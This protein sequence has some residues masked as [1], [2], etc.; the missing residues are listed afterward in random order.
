[1]VRKLFWAI[2]TCA[3]ALVGFAPGIAFAA[4]D[5]SDFL[6]ESNSCAT[7]YDGG[8][9]YT[10]GEIRPS[11]YCVNYEYRVDSLQY[12]NNINPGT[13][14][15]VVRWSF[16]SYYG[17]SESGT[18]ELHFTICKRELPF[19]ELSEDDDAFDEWGEVAWYTGKEIRPAL[20]AWES[21]AREGVDYT[22]SYVNNINPGTAKV[23]IAGKGLYGG[24]QTLTFRIK[25]RSIQRS[26]FSFVSGS[27]K[28]AYTGNA[29]KPK[30]DSEEL[31][32]GRD[33]LV[34]Y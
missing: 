10:G 24:S 8:F 28:Y 14:T 7:N 2:A 27:S 9:Y 4:P 18:T 12:R 11:V 15:I 5:S 25:K 32:K 3:V 1:M 21:G 26:D 34:S 23:V 29:V 6:I 20:E 31:V 19:F 30:I 17:G 13:A 33:Y 16:E 22:V